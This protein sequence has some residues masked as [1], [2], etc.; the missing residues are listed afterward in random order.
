MQQ[1]FEAIEHEQK[2]RD[3]QTKRLETEKAK[4]NIELQKAK[5]TQLRKQEMMRIDMATALEKERKN[6]EKALIESDKLAKQAAAKAESDSLK[7]QKQA[8]T[9]AYRAKKESDAEAYR[10]EKKA[11]GLKQ[12]MEAFG[13]SDHVGAFLEWHR[14]SAYWNSSNK[15]YYFGDSKDHMPKSFYSSSYA[16]GAH[17]QIHEQSE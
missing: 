14:T 12:L 16:G 3:L 7:A 17:Q 4:L 13:G 5:M 6:A 11:S 2:D 1:R 8:D 10:Q 15:V 9:E